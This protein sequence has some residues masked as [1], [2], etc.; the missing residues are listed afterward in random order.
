MYIHH[1]E[2]IKKIVETFKKDKNVLGVLLG[3]SIAHGFESENS[4]VDIMIIVS[5]ECYNEKFEKGVLTYW[6]NEIVTYDQGY[7]D[8]KYISLSF[9]EKVAHSGSEP[10]RYAFDGAVILYSTIDGLDKVLQKITRYPTEKKKEN[11]KRFYAQ[12]EAW[13]WYCYEGIKHNNAYLLNHGVSNL[14]LFGGRIILTYNNMLYPY[15]KWFMKVLDQ[16]EKKPED[17]IVRMDTLLSNKTAENIEA[18][19][20]SI[21][22][23]MPEEDKSV[24]WTGQFV[25]DSEINWMR[26]AVPVSDI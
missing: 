22:T 4:D 19:C 2:T 8:G 7:V 3:G 5:E 9:M 21:T 25:M 14:I 12:F 20:E 17:L 1:E 16:A 13:K 6:N 23:F 10:A 24:E 15:H 11:I 26:G 18:F